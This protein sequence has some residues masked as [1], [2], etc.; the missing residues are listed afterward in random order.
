MPLRPRRGRAARDDPRMRGRAARDGTRECLGAVFGSLLRVS[1]CDPGGGAAI[2]RRRTAC[3]PPPCA[4]AAVASGS[5]DRR[6]AAPPP[7]RAPRPRCRFHPSASPA[8]TSSAPSRPSPPRCESRRSSTWR[9]ARRRTR[10]SRLQ[11]VTIANRQMNFIPFVSVVAV[12]ARSS[13]RTRTRSRTTCSRPTT[14]S[15]TWAT[16]RRTAR[17]C[18]FKTPGAYTLLCNLHPGML[19]YLHGHA[20]DVVGE[21][22]REGEVRDEARAERHLQGR[23]RGRRGRRP[24]RSP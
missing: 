20:I 8:A 15:S 13:S 14:R 16:S 22:R 5:A 19:G 2:L 17:T 9:T 10:P 24:S 23:R 21:D 18:V 1:G 12:G 4:P 6:R 3:P 11:T 7:S